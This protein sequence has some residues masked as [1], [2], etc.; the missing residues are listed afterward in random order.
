MTARE[1]YVRVS[2]DYVLLCAL[3]TERRNVLVSFPSKVRSDSIDDSH[4]VSD[5]LI[6]TIILLTSYSVKVSPQN[7]LIKHYTGFEVRFRLFLV[8]CGEI[9]T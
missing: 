9:F 7:R 8:D 6:W 5:S 3:G 1:Y 4:R 2:R